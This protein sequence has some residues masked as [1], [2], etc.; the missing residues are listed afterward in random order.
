MPK[1]EI[2]LNDKTYNLL[3][4]VAQ[5]ENSTI[6]EVARVG[7]TEFLLSFHPELDSL[8]A[9]MEVIK[10]ELEDMKLHPE[11]YKTYTTVEDMLKDLQL[12]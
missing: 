8:N 3:L 1:I 6:Q 5:E 2:E 9:N 7:I 10:A 4:Q 11:R 12:D